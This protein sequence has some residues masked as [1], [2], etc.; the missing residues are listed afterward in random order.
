MFS[1]DRFV[2]LVNGLFIWKM[3]SIY[4]IA[5][6]QQRRGLQLLTAKMKRSGA[7]VTVTVTAIV[8]STSASVTVTMAASLTVKAIFSEM[9]TVIATMPKAVTMTATLIMTM[10]TVIMVTVIPLRLKVPAHLKMWIPSKEGNSLWI[11][12]DRANHSPSR[13]GRIR[14]QFG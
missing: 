1:L 7:A 13:Q 14:K 8:I 3:F 10:M 6:I 9:V 5:D 12:W 4:Q 2:S 11:S